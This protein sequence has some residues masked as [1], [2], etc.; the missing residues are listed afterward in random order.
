MIIDVHA[1]YH[2]RRYNEALAGITGRPAAGF[3]MAPHPDT[4]DEDHIQKRLEMMAEAGVGMQVLSPAA[5]RAPYAKDEA[6]AVNAA[7]L[8]NDL[9]A[10]LAQRYPDRFKAFV[11][12]PLPHVEASLQELKRGLD[13][14]GM[15]GVNMHISAL[16]RSVAEDEFLSIYDE[17]N[18]R[19]GIIFYHP[20][21]NGACCPMITDYGFSGAVGTSIEDT[22]IG[23]HLIAKKIP[24][25]CPYITYIIPH[26]GGPIAMLLQR[27]DNQFSMARHN[28]PEPPS[29]TAR[30]FYYDTVG[31]G[32]H[33]A[34]Q[35][36]A[37]AYGPDHILIGSDFPVLQSWETY[38]RTINWV[39][40]AGLAQTDVDQILERTAPSVLGL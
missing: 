18:R 31:H 23:L 9:T 29:V 10:K 24:A 6:A 34:L 25:R 8:C 3:A 22:V 26:L 14:L 39:R 7:S 27:L 15:I 2:P 16:D 17:I 33:A 11:S 30:R 38:E 20:S 28:L 36:A 40:D 19:R 32:S 21:G 12:L 5:G 4:D 13:G 1:H 37:M 35:C